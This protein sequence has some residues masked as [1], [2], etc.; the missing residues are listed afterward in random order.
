MH[1]FRLLNTRNKKEY[2]SCRYQELEAKYNEQLRQ[3]QITIHIKDLETREKIKELTEKLALESE[4]EHQRYE[5]L[6]QQ[7]VEADLEFSE[8]LKA[9]EVRNCVENCFLWTGCACVAAG[10]GLG[11]AWEPCAIGALDE[12]RACSPLSLHTECS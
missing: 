9:E 12:L 10:S 7:K 4:A 6:R 3:N 1:V 11:Y 5:T 8:R 2:K